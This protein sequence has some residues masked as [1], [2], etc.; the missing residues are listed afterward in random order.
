MFYK[1]TFLVIVYFSVV[2]ALS[3]NRII[4]IR[5]DAKHLP[6]GRKKFHVPELA[7]CIR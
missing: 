7:L 5:Y 4:K 1:H 2:L 6:F 3:L